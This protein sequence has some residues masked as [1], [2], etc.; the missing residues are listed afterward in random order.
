MRYKYECMDCETENKIHLSIEPDIMGDVYTCSRF[1]C[2]FCG[3]KHS[4]E[5]LEEISV[6]VTKEI[7]EH[8]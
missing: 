7:R 6:T 3:Y 1:H 5:E 8:V 2:Y 4:E